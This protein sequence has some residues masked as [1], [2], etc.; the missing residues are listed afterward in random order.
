MQWNIKFCPGPVQTITYNFR[1]ESVLNLT[2]FFKPISIHYYISFSPAIRR[3]LQAPHRLLAERRRALLPADG[4]RELERPDARPP[5]PGRPGQGHHRRQGLRPR[6]HG[7]PGQGV[8]IPLEIQ[9]PKRP[10]LQESAFFR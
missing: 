4:V 1:M 8:N 9:E 2:S 3:L 5:R 7:V 6:L 10:N